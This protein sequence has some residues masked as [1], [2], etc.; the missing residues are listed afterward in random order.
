MVRQIKPEKIT[1]RVSSVPSFKYLFEKPRTVI[2]KSDFQT[3][4]VKA[5]KI[6][7]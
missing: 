5:Y 3:G 6:G 2:K 1:P 7:K 4:C